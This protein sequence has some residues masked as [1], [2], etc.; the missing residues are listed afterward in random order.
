MALIDSELALDGSVYNV[1]TNEEISIIDLVKMCGEK[2]G[3][4]A[5]EIVFSG[6]RAS[7]PERRVLNTDKI[8]MKTGWRPEITL[9]QG[10][11]MCVE[12]M[13]K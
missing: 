9:E 13:Q 12:E 10:I 8:R 2:L 4:E 1:A 6:Y 5:P 7:D 11:E 3:I